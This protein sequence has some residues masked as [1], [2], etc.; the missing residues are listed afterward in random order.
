M[1]S[2]TNS[3]DNFIKRQ[4][5]GESGYLEISKHRKYDHDETKYDDQYKILEHDLQ[6]GK[7]VL[8]ATKLHNIDTSGGVLEFACGTG[9][10]STGLVKYFD[11]K[12]TLITDASSIFLDILK[13]KLAKNNLE[14]PHVGILRFEDIKKLPNNSLSLILLRSALHHID[15]Y[16]LFIKE[17][18]KKLIKDGAI[19]CQDPLRE[20][21]LTLGM[22]SLTASKL[23]VDKEIRTELTNMAR[24]AHFYCRGDTDKTHAE[25]KHV[26]RASDILQAGNAANLKL[27]FYPNFSLEDFNQDKPPKFNFLD[28]CKTYLSSC[29]SF[30]DKT[31]KYFIN[32]TKDEMNYINTLCE[33]DRGPE[34]SG[35]FLL[36]K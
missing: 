20:G 24:T 14:S 2:A 26:F 36:K 11:P 13:T 6:A 30:K 32:E 34:S 7:G 4:A 15:R 29:M 31:V 19:I 21:I 3:L 9:K 12:K 27:E 17:A 28:F 10:L 1:S 5:L 23:C 8:R 25:D 33:S 16:D 35:V 18:S 22:L